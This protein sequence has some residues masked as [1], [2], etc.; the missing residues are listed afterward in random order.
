MKQGGVLSPIYVDELLTRLSMSEF[1][2]MI[3]QKYYGAIGYA[4]DISLTAPSIYALNKMCNICLEFAS[5]YDLKFNPSKCQLAKYGSRPDSPFN[6][7]G[8]QVKYSK[9]LHL[10]QTV[11]PSMHQAMEKYKTSIVDEILVAQL[12]GRQSHDK[13][14]LNYV[15]VHTNNVFANATYL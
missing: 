1:G 11:G 15:S 10:G 3:G 5:E 7:D 8:T 14:Q 6:F 12:V 4:D 13:T 9:G 2:C